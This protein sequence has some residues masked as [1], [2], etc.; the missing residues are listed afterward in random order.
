[1]FDFRSDTD[2]S[3]WRRI[4]IRIKLIR[5]RNTEK[6]IIWIRLSPSQDQQKR[7]GSSSWKMDNGHQYNYKVRVSRFFK[8]SFGLN[9]LIV[10]F[11]VILQQMFRY[12]LTRA[13]AEKTKIGWPETASKSAQ[14]PYALGHKKQMRLL[15]PSQNIK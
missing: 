4:R 3:S 11:L 14:E 1:M 5:I 15:S 6:K 8:F 9:N 7:C 12:T 10:M 2:P 13:W